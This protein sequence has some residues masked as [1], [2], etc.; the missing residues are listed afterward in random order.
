MIIFKSEKKRYNFTEELFLLEI[1][2]FKIK[3]HGKIYGH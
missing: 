3:Y 1:R 2:T